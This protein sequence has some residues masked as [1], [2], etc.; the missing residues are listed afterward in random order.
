MSANH[1]NDRP[2]LWLAIAIPILAIALIIALSISRAF[3]GALVGLPDNLIAPPPPAGTPPA[4][5]PTS[6][7]T[8][9]AI[10]VGHVTWSGISQPNARNIQ[11]ISLTLMMGTIQVDYAAQNTD[12]SGFFTV[13]VGS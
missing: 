13:P 3:A 5:T 10:L 1:R 4:D 6:T 8:P 2:R 9:T 11:P 12:A 7:P